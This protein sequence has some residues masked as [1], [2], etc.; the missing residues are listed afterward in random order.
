MMCQIKE[1]LLKTAR[2]LR[3]IF[4]FKFTAKVKIVFIYPFRAE[5]LNLAIKLANYLCK[6][7]QLH[8]E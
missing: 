6:Y 4:H 3:N 1:M 8:E 5:W 7:P 2:T